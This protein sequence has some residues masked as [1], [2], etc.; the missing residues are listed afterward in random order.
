MNVAIFGGRF[1]P[2]HNGHLKVAKE[3]LKSGKADEVW[4]SIE[5]EHQ[6]RPIVASSED[7]I[8]MVNLAITGE[9]KFKID[10]TPIELGGLTETISVMR[11]IR[12]KN[13]ENTY[14]FVCGSDQPFSKWTYWE[15]LEKEVTFLI[16]P[17]KGSVLETVPKNCIVLDDVTYEPVDDSATRIRN[18]IKEGK[19]ITGLVPESVEKYIAEHE[20]YR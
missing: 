4:M 17:R 16:V 1:D 3:I 13:P 5:N 8:A 20:L 15:E 9:T 2:I 18:F 6:W 12:R 10:T 11:E 19:S 7:R 14:F